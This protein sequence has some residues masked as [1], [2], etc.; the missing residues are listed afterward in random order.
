MHQFSA[1]PDA[2]FF[3]SLYYLQTMRRIVNV[4]N[5]SGFFAISKKTGGAFFVIGSK[6]RSLNDF[7]G[8]A[9]PI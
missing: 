3:I 6:K 4:P 5:H 9:A 1:I 7:P 8:R 2:K